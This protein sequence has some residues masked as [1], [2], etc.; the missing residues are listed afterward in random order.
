MNLSSEVRLSASVLIPF[1]VTVCVL[2]I[3]PGSAFVLNV[4]P[5]PAFVLNFVPGP[6]FVLNV[7][8]GPAF[9]LIPYLSPSA[10]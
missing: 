3:V 5:G 6:A 4:V 1:T 2:N 9:V 7:V 8:P 10:S